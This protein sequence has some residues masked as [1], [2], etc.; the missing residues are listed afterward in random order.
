[1]I[2]NVLVGQSG[3]PTAVINASLCGVYETAKKMGAGKVYG[4]LYGIEGLMKE[5]YI[6]LD[7][8]L[9]NEMDIELLK[10]TPSA[11]LGSCRY[12]LSSQPNEDYDKIFEILNKLEITYFFYIGGN[13]SMDTIHKLSEYGKSINTPIRF[14]GI[15]KTIDNDLEITDHTPGFGSAAKFIAVT[16]KEII[17]D[18]L[19]YDMKSVTIVEIMGRNAGWLTGAAALAGERGKGG[20]DFI[21][22][23]ELPFDLEDFSSKIAELQKTKKSIVVAVSE[24]IK[25]ADGRYVCEA[26]TSG[27]DSFGHAALSGVAA[28]LASYLK[29]KLKIKTRAIELNTLQRCASHIASLVDIKEAHQIGGAAVNVSIRGETGKMMVFNRVSEYPYLCTTSSHDVSQIANKEKKIPL[30]WIGEDGISVT[31]EFIDYVK[32]LVGEELLP[33]MIEGVP[34]HL[35]L[36]Q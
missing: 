4:M 2:G 1:M 29:D 23:P 24:G 26:E 27:T 5:K 25:L 21:Y 6:D 19:V 31:Q 34:K 30:N 28:F 15:P 7:K 12:K 20:V 18:S 33:V 35:V 13:D 14:I 3:G 8:H 10:R 16:M 32:P 22:L 11:Y 17:R 9:S 36:E